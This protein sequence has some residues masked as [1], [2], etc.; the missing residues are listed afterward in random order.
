MRNIVL[1]LLLFSFLPFSSKGTAQRPDL[2]IYQGDTLALY[3]NPLEAYYTE[4]N[5]RPRNFGINSCWSTACWRGYQA[6]WE[7]RED[8]LYLLAIMDCCY[9]N[10][11]KITATSLDSLEDKLPAELLMKLS[12]LQGEEIDE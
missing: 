7:I 12:S 1:L 10:D 9:R 5:P 4:Q 6:L 11:Y 3:A 2:L 8:H